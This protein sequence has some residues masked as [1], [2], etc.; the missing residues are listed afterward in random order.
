MYKTIVIWHSSLETAFLVSPSTNF[1][2]SNSLSWRDENA[3]FFLRI[4][5]LYHRA[6]NTYKR[7]RESWWWRFNFSMLRWNCYSQRRDNV[8]KAIGACPKFA[9]QRHNPNMIYHK[10]NN[11]FDLFHVI[12][13]HS[14]Y[15]ASPMPFHLESIL[16]TT[17]WFQRLL[18]D[19]HY[20]S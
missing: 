4:S 16:P 12:F 6:R 18:Q 19:Y 15:V 3:E 2:L 1:Y 7:K 8:E 11:S 9:L 10:V 20:Q 5:C 14:T 17:V 13:M